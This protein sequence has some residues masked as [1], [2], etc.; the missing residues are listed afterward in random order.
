MSSGALEKARALMSSVVE[1]LK[2]FTVRAG[3]GLHQIEVWVDLRTSWIYYST[4]KTDV[5]DEEI[6]LELYPPCGP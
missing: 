3:A 6:Q 2:K 5:F 1:P 4:M